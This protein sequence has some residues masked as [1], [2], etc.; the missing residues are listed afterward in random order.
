MFKNTRQLLHKTR[1]RNNQLYEKGYKGI[2]VL[3]HRQP[4][5]YEKRCVD[6]FFLAKFL[7]I[8]YE[9]IAY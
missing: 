6:Y 5:D 1:V 2:I 8:G 4:V 7:S 9:S 3:S